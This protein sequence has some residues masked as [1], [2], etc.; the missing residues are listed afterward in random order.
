MIPIPQITRVDPWLTAFPNGTDLVYP[1]VDDY[2]WITKIEW[3]GIGPSITMEDG[4]T[5]GS[6]ISRQ[7][8]TFPSENTVRSAAA[9]PPGT[10]GVFHFNVDVELLRGGYLGEEPR[11]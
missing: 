8:K 6:F 7:A 4:I 2:W 9:T 5:R 11:D 1:G 3:V 10:P